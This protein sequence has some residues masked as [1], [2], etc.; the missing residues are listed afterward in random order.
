MLPCFTY[1]DKL[2]VAM[3]T[4]SITLRLSCRGV[5]A[6]YCYTKIGMAST[7]M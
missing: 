5:N 2:F 6:A 7:M 3:V 4:A 1:P